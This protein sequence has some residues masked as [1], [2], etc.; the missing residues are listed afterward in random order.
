MDFEKEEFDGIMLPVH[1]IPADVD[2]LKKFPELNKYWEFLEEVPDKNKVIRYIVFFYDRKTPLARIDNIP[3]RKVEAALLAGFEL[4]GEVFSEYVEEVLSCDNTI[5]NAMIVRYL[6]LNNNHKFAML[7]TTTE[8]FY[9]E[10]REQL[11]GK[12]DFK[13]SQAMEKEITKITEELTQGDNNSNLIQ[14]MYQ[15]V[16]MEKI[17]LSPEDIAERVAEGL[18]GV[19][20]N[21]Y[22]D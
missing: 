14:D 15:L 3:S 2:L 1:N 18:P 21:P 8:L 6:R 10:L 19:S 20:Y 4:D 13:K 17:G 9:R 12:G 7:S 5:V 11:D 22:K 16:D